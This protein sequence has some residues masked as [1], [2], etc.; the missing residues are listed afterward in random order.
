MKKRILSILAMVCM[1][2]VLF[3]M[4]V[5]A[6]ASIAE[7][8]STQDFLD[9]L[10]S[11]GLKYQYVGMGDNGE[12]IRVS[13]TL[14]NFDA[15][16]CNLFFKDDCEEVSLRVWDI[17][18]ATAG[19]NHILSTLNDIEQG[20]KFVKYVYDASD[21][22]IQAEIDMYIDGDHCGRS[23]YDAMMVMFNLTD[24]DDVAEMLHALE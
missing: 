13:F 6:S 8:D 11:K 19:K 1:L 18:T 3:S 24:D 22:T 20:Y 4:P 7:L 15:L 14:D 5:A 16:T 17:V 21:S 23:V 10:D 9:F 2:A 12:Q